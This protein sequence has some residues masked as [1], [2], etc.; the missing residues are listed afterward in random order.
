M[1]HAPPEPPIDLPAR[2]L[3]LRTL[4]KSDALYRVHQMHL[5]AKHFGRSGDWRFDAPDASYG[6]LYAGLLPEVSFAETLLR[7]AGH[8]AQSEI[9]RRSLCRFLVLRPLRLV[10]MFGPYMIRI[11]A[12]A[13]VTSGVDHGCSQR[14]SRALY[15][16]SARPDG[17]IYRA[18]HDNDQLAAV[19]FDRAGNA[20]DAGTTAPVLSDLVL[21]GR[22]LERYKA[23]IR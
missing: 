17:I 2:A 4:P 10:R 21:L 9:A 13:G 18:T 3:P 19:L 23:S 16:H 1:P 20:L 11:R 6:T 12:N 15:N 5:S 14:W 22:I 8:V 7:G